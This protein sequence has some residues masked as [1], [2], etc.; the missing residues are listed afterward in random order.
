MS[1]STTTAT[2][3][4][5]LDAALAYAE[6]GYKVFPCRAG[7][8]R[9]ATDHGV[10]DATTD[11]AQIEAWWESITHNIGIATDGLLVVDVDGDNNPWLTPEVAHQL[12][13]APT[14]ITPRGGRHYIFRG[15]D[16]RNTTSKLASNVD[17]RANGGYIVA[18]PSVVDGKPYRWL[19][20]ADLSCEPNQL[21]APPAWIVEALSERRSESAKVATTGDA[22]NNG[23]R[24][25][26]LTS[27]AGKLRNNGLNERE[28]HAALS[29]IN[30]GRCN[31]PLD[32]AEVA[33]IAASVSRYEGGKIEVA[34]RPI[35]YRRI[36]SAELAT[37][38]YSLTYA[39]EDAM[40]DG[41][42]MI[43]AGQSKTLKTSLIIDAAIALA[44]GGWW[45]GKFRV[46]EAKRV[47]VMSGESGLATLQ[48]TAA[49]ICQ[50][51]N[52][53]LDN[54][55]NLLWSDSL[56]QFGHAL[57]LEAIE[58]FLTDDE[59]EVL[60][61]DPAYLCIP[62]DDS[63]NL[64]KQGELLREMSELCQRIGVTLCIAHHC[65]KNTGREAGD[66]PELSDIAWAGFGEFARQW[67]LVGRRERYEPG[68]G[69]HKLWLS[70]GGSAGHGSG[71]A[72]DIEE[73]VRTDFA[74]RKWEVELNT[75][76]EVR[77]DA[78][79]R[80]A[81]ARVNRE[82]ERLQAQAE[83]DRS[84]VCKAMAKLKMADTTK[85]IAAA[86]RLPNNRALA[87][88][89]DLEESGD[90]RG[91]EITKNNHKYQGYELTGND[92]E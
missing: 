17:T 44:T 79:Q 91:V 82:Q 25:A 66:M 39:I 89:L 12:I 63:G 29:A 8:K 92:R 9:P 70:I 61:L 75:A 23:S 33:T 20:D 49:R 73:G 30:I 18:A 32:L 53:Q 72:L 14:S 74:P 6:L 57:H 38:D 15:G 58:R 81:E 71:W 41:Q 40:V 47:M 3:A 11:P 77:T 69:S 83:A 87:A 28:M 13:G 56:P 35:E 43:I 59:I 55:Y 1:D 37:G 60:F 7:E 34:E 62:A 19:P 52:Q 5:L 64:M 65:K 80:G 84:A 31:P 45:L 21:P 88:L 42:P 68:T 16:F 76:T 50:V 85:S 24:N 27:I 90:V 2:K 4:N 36:T 48:E 54:I 78:K 51:A 26:T 46:P 86:A 10:L 22:I 67:W